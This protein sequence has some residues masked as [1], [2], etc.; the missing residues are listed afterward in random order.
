MIMQKVGVLKRKNHFSFFNTENNDFV[1][2]GRGGSVSGT[3]FPII[4]RNYISYSFSL[5]I[6]KLWSV[7]KYIITTNEHST[8]HDGKY[9]YSKKRKGVVLSD[10]SYF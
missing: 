9:M 4:P 2:R 7:L 3:Y 6:F 10:I 1:Y 8:A 5:Y